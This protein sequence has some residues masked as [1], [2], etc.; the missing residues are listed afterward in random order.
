MA[1]DGEKAG[2]D[3]G[4]Y[5][6]AALAL[7]LAVAGPLVPKHFL[8]ERSPNKPYETFE[9]FYPFYLSQ[10]QD[11]TCRYLH[12]I[13]S[14]IVLYMVAMDLNIGVAI[15]IA[16]C[17]GYGM[18]HATAFM[19]HGFVE[20]GFT[21]LTYLYARKKLDGTGYLQSAKV[22]SIGYIFAWI[23]HHFYEHNKP[24][25]FIYPVYSLAGDYRMFWD[26]VYNNA[27][28]YLK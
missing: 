7:G 23:G 12:F 24:A 10:H 28:T 15:L 9:S 13:G 11:E 22:A 3:S 20:F 1:K 21:I 18:M 27:S 8:L 17:A 19:D 14:T 2:I 26:F 16:A 5:L 25:T 4:L 6:L